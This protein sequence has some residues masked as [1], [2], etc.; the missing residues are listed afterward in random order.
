[1]VGLVETGLKL[2][3]RR[4][5]LTAYSLQL[6]ASAGCSARNTSE[7]IAVSRR[8]IANVRQ[9]AATDKQIDQLVSELYGL[10]K[11]EVRIVEE[12]ER[13]SRPWSAN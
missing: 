9:I 12:R 3:E 10:T 5:T 7:P 2:Y 6:A 8:P 13:Q 4:R 1:M 11:E